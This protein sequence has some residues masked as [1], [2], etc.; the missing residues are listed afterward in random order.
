[1]NSSEVRRTFLDFFESKGHTIVPSSTLVPDDPTLLFANAG[2]VQFK[3]LFLGEESRAYTRAV[4]AQKC[5]R[6]SGKHNDIEEVGPSP[7]H[8]TFFEMLGNFSF[9]DYFKDDAIQYAWE[10]VTEIL[11]LD[12]ERLWATVFH[13][14]DEAYELWLKNSS[15]PTERVLRLGEKD[16]WWSMGDTG[17]NGPCSEMFYDRG[18]DKCTCALQGKCDPKTAS[19][20]EDCNRFWEFWN[21]VFMQYHTH[22]DGTT[23]P[24]ENPSVDTGLGL[25]RVTAILQNA[26][27]NYDTD[28]FS[29]IFDAVRKITGN[30]EAEMQENYVSYRVIAD[31]GRAMSFISTEGVIPGN[32]DR[33]YVLRMLIRRALRF[34]LKIGLDKP[35]LDKV[36][37]AVIQQMG[38]AYPELRERKEFILESVM[39]EEEKFAKTFS[40]RMESLEKLFKQKSAQGE[41]VIS[42]KDAFTMH[43][44]HGF[45]V[46]IL[47]DIAKERGFS[48]DREAYEAEM[49][50]QRERSKVEKDADAHALDDLN[51]NNIEPTKFVGY[52]S[53][54][55][56]SEIL[57][58]ERDSHGHY[59]VV[60]GQTSLYAEGGGQTFDTGRIV[61]QS[62]TGEGTL[63]RVEKSKRGHFV[64]TLEISSGSFEVG[65]QCKLEVD[66]ER[67]RA[68]ERNHTATHILHAALRKVLEHKTGIQAG[69]RVT[70]DEL[71]FD[72]THFSQVSPEEITKIEDMANDVV[73]R[74]LPIAI[75][76]ESLE[77]AK[78]I[79]AMAMF[80]E[81][82]E[83]KEHVRVVSIVDEEDTGTPFSIELCGGTHVKRTGEIGLFK[84]LHEEGVA[85][86]IRRVYVSTGH[87]ALEHLRS[88]EEII[89][90]ASEKL[91][92]ADHDL[93][94]K[95]NAVLEQKSVLER[96]L[97]QATSANLSDQTG[98]IV[99]EAVAVGK[100]KALLKIV[101]LEVDQMKELADLIEA[102]MG[103]GV[104]LL[105]SNRNGR[106]VLIAKVSESLTKQIRAGDLIRQAAEIVGGKGGG[107]PRF[108]QGGGD[109]PDQLPQA[110]EAVKKT[111]SSSL[112]S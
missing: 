85:S 54:S 73:L 49:E 22:A 109:A 36:C 88:R 51:L 89:R 55:C 9:G 1:M 12:P 71:R 111:L 4:T 110:L 92:S 37:L 40:T 14:D 28:L 32:E 65:D 84:I 69:S 72:F 18:I 7:R 17:P 34:G 91:K 74:D 94:Q 106:A 83:G 61:N 79:G 104:V 44:T 60:L 62:Q 86:G 13:E 99:D 105:G 5:A 19:E 103:D 25:E 57:F 16:N 11:K 112:G 68:I 58:I 66:I 67:R 52:E 107:N 90:E 48:V 45:H 108:A 8:H 70:D 10:Y 3:N 43:D 95:L 101:D 27:S 33:S 59:L 87:N 47:E 56:D 29:P 102:R 26:D 15:I 42:G 96:E 100:H 46:Q 75:T 41:K 64:H 30:S 20:D 80:A 93:L 23:T 39:Q 97:K 82:Y 78:A 35:F 50:L 6:L 38:E 76:E 53:A 2:M 98:D 24:L 31:H 63:T 77:S 21:L 81:D